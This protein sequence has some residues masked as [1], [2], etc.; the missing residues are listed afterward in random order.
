MFVAAR[1]QKVAKLKEREK[2][3]DDKNRFEVGVEV[4]HSHYSFILK[5]F[6][7][8]DV[9]AEYDYPIA[10]S[11]NKIYTTTIELVVSFPNQVFLS[12]K[13]PPGEVRLDH[14]DDEEDIHFPGSTYAYAAQSQYVM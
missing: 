4:L 2:K 7:Y 1:S 5:F 8:D 3:S 10:S 13:S 14:L 11:F 9:T 6:M 12:Q